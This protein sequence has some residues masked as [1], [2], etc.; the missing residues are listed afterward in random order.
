MHQ[1]NGFRQ[2]A[3][4]AITRSGIMGHLIGGLT[5]GWISIAAVMFITHR[6]NILLS[7]IPA[8][9]LVMSC[10]P[11][12]PVKLRSF[13]RA[14]CVGSSIMVSPM[15]LLIYSAIGGAVFAYHNKFMGV[16]KTLMG[17]VLGLTSTKE[18]TLTPDDA[19]IR[20]PYSYQGIDYEV[21][22]PWTPKVLGKTNI[23][24]LNPETKVWEPYSNPTLETYMGP[25]KKF[26]NGYVPPMSLLDSTLSKRH[27]KIRVVTRGVET[28]YDLPREHFSR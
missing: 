10:L 18:A 15:T 13:M 6:W 23:Q 11:N 3:F 16:Y 9:F 22:L 2:L 12:I 26:I 4:D 19:Y 17:G 27:N 1:N 8:G 24:I 20:I 21:A 5:G 25:N 7:F 14:V 28:V